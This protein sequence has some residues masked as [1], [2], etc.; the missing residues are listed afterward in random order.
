MLRNHFKFRIVVAAGSL[1]YAGIT[2]AVLMIWTAKGRGDGLI[3]L[4]AV[5][6]AVYLV[7]VNVVIGLFARRYRFALAASQ[8][9]IAKFKP[10]IVQIGEVPLKAFLLF[11]V[12]STAYAGVLVLDGGS[13]G[14]GP[15]TR[16]A[17]FVFLLSLTMFGAAFLYVLTDRLVSARLREERVTRYPTD[18]DYG[19]QCIKNLVIPLAI[20]IMTALFSSSLADM[21]L[22]AYG[23]DSGLVVAKP[24]FLIPIAL[25]FAVIIVL[26]YLWMSENKV[27]FGGLTVQMKKL[28]SAN[29]D[30]TERIEIISVDELGLISGLI[31]EFCEGLQGN[32]SGIK[33]AQ[34]SLSSLG[35]DLT[36]SAQSQAGAIG[37]IAASVALVAESITD[38]SASV[39]ES[40]SAVEEIAKNI[41]SMDSLISEQA[42]SVAEASA[43]IEE[44][45]ANIASVT[46]S[47]EKM[48]E[49]YSELIAAAGVGKRAQTE[50][51]ERIRL[52]S[53]RS[54][55]LLEANK[56][57]A[58]ISSQTN[59]LAMN[60]AIEAAHAGDA[61]RGFSVVADEIRHLA[62]NSGKQSK[63]IKKEI[64]EVQRAIEGVVAASAGSNEAFSTVAELIGETDAI[65]RETHSALVAQ[66][67]GSMQVLEALKSMNRITVQVR[68]GSKEMSM[69]NTSVL[70]EIGRL[71]G[72]TAE[73]RDSMAGME[74]AIKDISVHAE[75]VASLAKNAFTAIEKVDSAI[76]TFKT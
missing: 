34:G 16:G 21:V 30:L 9:D 1:A 59:L 15:G 54:K 67:D 22:C 24:A 45:V 13:L 60:A 7:V 70:E 42:S 61:G 28:V 3:P 18:Y 74:A 4:F 55:A 46:S 56:V 8:D 29:K 69:G 64:G 6:S 2:F 66:R 62:E 58:T 23:A 72:N 44:M 19:R 76:G 38:Q 49:Q 33:D 39:V 57:I 68:D 47:M 40:S 32:V 48:A 41:E 50:S 31:N 35:A 17:L 75:K 71:Q 27:I 10:A 37:Q 65:V 5:A 12:I 26:V 51:E 20:A 73:I 36:G 11:I 53:E 43:S 63:A 14:D 25:Y 52:I